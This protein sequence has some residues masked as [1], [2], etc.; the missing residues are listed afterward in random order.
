M[1]K[2][3][4]GFAG[5]MLATLGFVGAVTG[6]LLGSFFTRSHIVSW[7]WRI[8]FLLGGVF[9]IVIYFLRR[10]LVET[11]TFQDIK[12]KGKVVKLPILSVLRKRPLN[13]LRGVGIGVN[14]VT[15]FYLG[16]IY[17]NSVL[18][19]KFHLAASEVLA[20]NTAIMLLWILLLPLA[21]YISDKIGKTRLMAFS[22]IGTLLLAYPSFLYIHAVTSLS[23][24]ITFQILISL[25]SICFV[26]PCSAVLPELFPP[27]ER[28][29]GSAFSYSLGVAILGGTAP[30]IVA[31][32][33]NHGFIMGPAFYLIFS[34][35]LGFLA[36]FDVK[37]FQDVKLQHEVKHKLAA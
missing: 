2:E 11:P 34:S 31:S 8:P 6:T 16:I 27:E 5:S 18:K 35:I 29:S 3:Q 26:A 32:L 13:I 21:G 14:T 12:N 37:L 19:S 33:V 24:L 28:Y 20:C 15:P 36:V 7:G 9:G 1:K 25:L 10:N 17:M 23:A 30:L 4:V 22:A